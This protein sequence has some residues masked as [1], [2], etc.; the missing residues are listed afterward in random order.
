MD[1]EKRIQKLWNLLKAFQPVFEIL[2]LGFLYLL[3]F[4]IFGFGIPCVFRLLTGYRCPGCG[5]TH[6]VAELSRGHFHAAM[7]ENALCLTVLPVGCVYMLYRFIRV[8]IKKKEGFYVWEY[9]LMSVLLIIAV[10]YG[11]IRNQV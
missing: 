5:M 1:V 2:G 8:E 7:Q 11:Y 4:R 10:G 3:F 9:F 6:A